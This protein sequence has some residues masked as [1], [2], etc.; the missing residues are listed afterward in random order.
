MQES[1]DR[2]RKLVEISPDAVFLH[3]EGKIIYANPATFTLLGATHPDEIIGKN[4]L[5][6]VSPEF[7]DI[8]REN[9]QKDLRGT[10]YPHEPN[11]TW[12]ALTGHQ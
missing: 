12:F 2:Y 11:Y 1:E 8:V 5:D 4:V 3:R 6:F 7:R 9:I 10:R